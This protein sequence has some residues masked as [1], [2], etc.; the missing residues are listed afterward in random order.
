MNT[1]SAH[2]IHLKQDLKLCRPVSCLCI[3]VTMTGG[4]LL[5]YFLGLMLLLISSVGQMLLRASNVSQWLLSTRVQLSI[6]PAGST[7]LAYRH[8]AWGCQVD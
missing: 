7:P 8:G 4:L 1:Q 5:I 3:I 6:R 2:L